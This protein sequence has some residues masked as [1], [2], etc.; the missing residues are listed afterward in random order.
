MGLGSERTQI[1]DFSGNSIAETW[2]YLAH[3]HT[4]NVLDF[5]FNIVF[6]NY[7]L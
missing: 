1:R 3:R 5:N 2:N 4:I 6:A 7:N